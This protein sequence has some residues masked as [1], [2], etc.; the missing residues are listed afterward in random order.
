LVYFHVRPLLIYSARNLARELADGYYAPRLE[1]LAA[2]SP[3]SCSG[4]LQTPNNIGD[5][6]KLIKAICAATLLSLSLSVPGYADTSP[7]DQHTPGSPARIQSG[8]GDIEVTGKATTG[9]GDISFSA[10][11]DM[12][13]TVASI[14]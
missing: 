6:M 14:F 11:A 1:I 10:L 12:L 4:I 7:G 2:D 8:A 3:S 9:D 5:R 13:W